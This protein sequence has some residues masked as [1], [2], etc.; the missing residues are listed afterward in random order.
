MNEN[1]VKRVMDLMKD[2]IKFPSDM[3]G[4]KYF[5][6]EPDF[7]YSESPD[8]AYALKKLEKLMPGRPIGE[9]Q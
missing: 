5:F 4:H 2:R 1:K 6:I 7:Q 9:K 8:K 3:N